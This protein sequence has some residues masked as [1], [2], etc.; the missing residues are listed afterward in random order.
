[1]KNLKYLVLGGL[2][3]IILTK[4]EVVSW[5]RIQEMFR[6]QSFHMYGVIGSAIAVGLVSLQLIKRNRLKSLNGEVITLADKKYTHGAWIGGIIF[7]LGWA[8]TGAC[9]G[10]MFAQLGSGVASAAVLILAALAGT[11]TYSALREKLPH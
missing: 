5:W 1:M 8:L 11:W 9:P 4:S 7:G 6:F 3:G 2:F 10:P